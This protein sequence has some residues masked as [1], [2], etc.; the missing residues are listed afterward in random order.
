MMM[1]SLIPGLGITMSF[2]LLGTGYAARKIAGVWGGAPMQALLPETV[3]S[4]QRAISGSWGGIMNGVSDGV[5]AVLA[6]ML[7]QG[8]LGYIDS[9]VYCIVL[10]LVGTVANAV[11]FSRRPGWAP[12]PTPPL[13]LQNTEAGFTVIGVL[14]MGWDGARS[15]F[16]CHYFVAPASSFSW[17][18]S[19]E[20][21]VG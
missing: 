11:S 1:S 12:E 13:T 14:K 21:E 20:C 4:S 10:L 7:G 18:L 16:F 8:L 19:C 17:P 9:Y 5:A 6:V 15:L 3:P 2:G